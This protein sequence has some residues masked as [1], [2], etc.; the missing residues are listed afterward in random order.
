[1]LLFRWLHFKSS[2]VCSRWLS[3]NLR[4]RSFPLMRCRPMSLTP[5]RISLNFGCS[6]PRS[7]QSGEL[8]PWKSRATFWLHPYISH[9]SVK[10]GFSDLRRH[11]WTSITVQQ[12]TL[13]SC[14]SKVVCKSKVAKVIPWFQERL[15][16]LTA[17]MQRM[18]IVSAAIPRATSA[19]MAFELDLKPHKNRF[20]PPSGSSL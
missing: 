2:R 6:I 16:V 8:I 5:L 3:Y 10:S 7:L 9:I 15:F 4:F 18:T 13:Q 1:M 11:C 12:Q 14:L 17:F 20:A 19:I